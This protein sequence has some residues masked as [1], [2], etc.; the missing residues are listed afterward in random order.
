[1][2]NHKLMLKNI[3]MKNFL[4]WQG[5]FI[6]QVTIETATCNFENLAVPGTVFHRFRHCAVCY[7]DVSYSKTSGNNYVYL[8]KIRKLVH[9]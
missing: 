6:E 1:M 8:Q 3:I 9:F 5:Y 2:S 4:H 7:D